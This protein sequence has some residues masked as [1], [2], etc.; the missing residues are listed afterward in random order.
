MHLHVAREARLG[1]VG[2]RASPAPTAPKV[3]NRPIAKASAAI[4]QEAERDQQPA[5]RAP[6]AGAA[7]LIGVDYCLP[8]ASSAPVH[9]G[10]RL[11]DVL[12][13]PVLL[14]ELRDPLVVGG[15][16]LQLVVP[17]RSRTIGESRPS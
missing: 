12:A 8:G 6:P 13:A 17:V 2:R 10:V 4:E 14:E 9:G 5:P 15:V 16:E 11:G 1:G 7:S 3:E